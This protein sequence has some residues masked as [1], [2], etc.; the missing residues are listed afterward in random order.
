V[1]PPQAAEALARLLPQAQLLQIGR[2]GHAP[3]ISHPRQVSAAV[4][5]FLRPHATVARQQAIP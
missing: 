4:L 1:T 3:F 5:E 2:A